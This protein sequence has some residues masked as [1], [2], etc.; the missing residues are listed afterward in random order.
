MSELVHQQYNVN[1]ALANLLLLVL[2]VGA[3]IGVLVGGRLGDAMLKRRFL[4]CRVFV[5][6]VSCGDRGAAFVPALPPTTRPPRC[7]T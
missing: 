7:P 3:V 2:G 1:Q 5:A 6:A 4:N